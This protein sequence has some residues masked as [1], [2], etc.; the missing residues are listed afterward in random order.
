MLPTPAPEDPTRITRGIVLILFAFFLFGVMDAT[1]KHLMDRYHFTQIMAIR[2]WVFFL[3]ALFMIRRR[4]F[5]QSLKSPVVGLQILRAVILIVEMACVVFSFSLLPLADVHAVLTM[6]PL[7]VL[8][9]AGVALGE[10]I[11]MRGWTA[12]LAGFIGALLIIRPGMEGFSVTLLV[13][14]CGAV[15]WASYQVLARLVGRRDPAETTLLYTTIVGIVAF[16]VLAPFTWRMPVDLGDAA[17]LLFVAILGTVGHFSIIKAL[18]LS[19]AS[20]LQPYNY[21]VF[22][23][24]VFFGFVVFADMPD[25]PTLAGTAI[26][27]A[28]GIVASDRNGRLWARLRRRLRLGP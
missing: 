13:P 2:F 3:F 6:A 22:L 10:T 7:M 17:L 1:S 15:L 9:M 21:S 24:A 12:V 5:R 26:I 25:G 16:S 19:P 4:G 20:I 27:V 28:A 18:T 14:L 11:G 8:L 23:W